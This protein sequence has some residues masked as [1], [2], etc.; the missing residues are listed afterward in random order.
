MQSACA[1]RYSV[2]AYVIWHKGLACG[3][4]FSFPYRVSLVLCTRSDAIEN[5]HNK[6]ERGVRVGRW[7]AWLSVN[8][9]NVDARRNASRR[10]LLTPIVNCYC[11]T[12]RETYTLSGLSEFHSTL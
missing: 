5:V 1:V 6:S 3:R 12:L 2:C 9:R 7:M 4:F 8:N 11:D 10:Q